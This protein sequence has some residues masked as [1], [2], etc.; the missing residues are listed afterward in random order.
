MMVFEKVVPTAQEMRPIRRGW[1]L[2]HWVGFLPGWIPILALMMFGITVDVLARGALPPFLVSGFL[3]ASFALWRLSG[4]LAQKTCMDEARKAPVGGLDWCWTIDEQGLVFDNGLQV[5]RLDWR[6]VK[7]V[8]E[9]TDR[10]LFLV[11]PGNNPVLPVRLMDAGQVDALRGLIT[12]L[13]ASGRLG[14]GV[15][16]VARP[17]DKT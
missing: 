6:G 11:S 7:A 13:K 17:S 15:D 14:A 5:N 9:E 2:I 10:F 8:R 16:Y 12:G 3:I 1:G 4:R